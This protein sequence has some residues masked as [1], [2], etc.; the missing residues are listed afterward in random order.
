MKLMHKAEMRRARIEMI[1]LMDCIFLLLTFFIYASLSMTLHRG[2]KVHLP[3]ASTAEV[4][5]QSR[6]TISITADGRLYLDKEQVTVNQLLTQVK[7]RQQKDK[8]LAVFINADKQAHVG[9]AIT[10][11]DLLRKNDVTQ[12]SFL[13]TA[14]SKVV[15]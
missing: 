8:K 15:P 13:T 14:E 6:L 11:L 12:V 10:V 9:L 5:K 1:P 4:E 2:I 7:S 3:A